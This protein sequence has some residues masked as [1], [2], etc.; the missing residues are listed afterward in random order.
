MVTTTLAWTLLS[1]LNGYAARKEDVMDDL[2]EDCWELDCECC[3]SDCECVECTYVY[4]ASLDD[5][6]MDLKRREANEP[7]G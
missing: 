6:E 7:M 3:A 4:D 2:C 5:L 1:A